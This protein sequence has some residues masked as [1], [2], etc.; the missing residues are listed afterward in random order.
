[1]ITQGLLFCFFKKPFS[2]KSAVPT[3][4]SIN[5]ICVRH[6]NENLF[7][8]KRDY[9]LS[10]TEWKICLQ[11]VPLEI[12]KPIYHSPSHNLVAFKMS[13]N[14]EFPI[15]SKKIIPNKMRTKV[16]VYN[17]SEKKI[18]QNQFIASSKRAVY[19]RYG[20]E[21]FLPYVE[22]ECCGVTN[23]DGVPVMNPDIVGMIMSNSEREQHFLMLPINLILHFLKMYDQRIQSFQIV[24]PNITLSYFN[25]LQVVKIDSNVKKFASCIETNEIYGVMHPEFNIIIPLKFMYWYYAYETM[26]IT[27]KD[28]LISQ[29]YTTIHNKINYPLTNLPLVLSDKFSLVYGE[30]I[31]R[32]REASQPSGNEII[33]DIT[34]DLLMSMVD[35]DMIQVRTNRMFDE[36]LEGKRFD[37]KRIAFSDSGN[38]RIID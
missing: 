24:Y 31:N 19:T 1:M 8:T 28:Q 14:H 15:L 20:M 17:Y 2:W 4:Y 36:Y 12:V 33:T 26:N 9:V 32:A 7:I 5:G 10:Y 6:S 37:K 34:G 23:L 35:C 30:K 27:V 22:I 18:I 13:D 38:F 21:D 11:G 16:S 3:Q 25:G 29:E